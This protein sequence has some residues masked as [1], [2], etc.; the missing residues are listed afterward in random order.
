VAPV[1]DAA[2]NWITGLI[3]QIKITTLSLNCK[4]IG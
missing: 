3:N 4:R 1:Y 2:L